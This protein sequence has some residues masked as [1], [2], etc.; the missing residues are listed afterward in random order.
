MKTFKEAVEEIY[1][2]GVAK[3]D[4]FFLM[5]DFY[6]DPAYFSFWDIDDNVLLGQFKFCSNDLY[7]EM[8][9]NRLVK[10]LTIE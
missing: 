1:R 5:L 2:E 10:E 9:Y 6:Q 8:A 3:F 7:M 4:S